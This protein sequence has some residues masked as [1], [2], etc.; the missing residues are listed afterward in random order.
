MKVPIYCRTWGKPANQCRCLRC[1][2]PTPG[3]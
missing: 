3:A 1:T 2:Q